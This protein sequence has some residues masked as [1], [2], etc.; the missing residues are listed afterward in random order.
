[1][2]TVRVGVT[3]SMNRSYLTSI[4]SLVFI[5]AVD[6]P[7]L[8]RGRAGPGLAD[9]LIKTGR[10]EKFRPVHSSSI[11]HSRPVVTREQFS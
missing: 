7:G 3:I 6:G 10:A 4:L 2:V 1:M 11:Y 5:R 8:Q 9:T